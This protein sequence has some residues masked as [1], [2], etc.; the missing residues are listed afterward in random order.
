MHAKKTT[1]L[2]GMCLASAL[3]ALAVSAEARELRNPVPIGNAE[4][5]L[6]GFKLYDAALLT[7]NGARFD[8]ARPHALELTYARSFDRDAL[9]DATLKE[10]RRIEGRREDHGAMIETLRPCFRDVATGDRLEATA[11]GP[12]KLTFS[13][14]GASTCVVEG[15]FLATR[16]LSIW[17]SD[18]ARDR[19]LSQQL[20]G[21]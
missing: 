1:Y 12:S 4:V 21:E 2:L 13:F 9:L 14:N 6:F 19:R 11:L 15:P 20:R 16:F 7:T 3:S 18:K 10:M 17:L 8:P 5:R